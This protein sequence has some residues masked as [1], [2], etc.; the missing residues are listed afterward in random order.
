MSQHLR[1]ADIAYGPAKPLVRDIVSKRKA[2]I[3]PRDGWSPDLRSRISF[4]IPP[5]SNEYLSSDFKLH[6]IY[7]VTQADGTNI[8]AG[9][10]CHSFTSFTFFQYTYISECSYTKSS[11]HLAILR[12]RTECKFTNSFLIKRRRNIIGLDRR[13]SS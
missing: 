3:R 5:S 10:V 1:S 2:L 12:L 13:S 11:T 4:D 6:L 8:A 9:A 7:S